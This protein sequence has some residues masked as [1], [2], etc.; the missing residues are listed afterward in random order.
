[1]MLGVTVQFSVSD[2]TF[3]IS[4]MGLLRSWFPFHVIAVFPSRLHVQL[5]LKCSALISYFSHAFMYNLNLWPWYA[6][7][8]YW[9]FALVYGNNKAVNFHQLI[10]LHT[11]LIQLIEILSPTCNPSRA[12][13]FCQILKYLTKL[14]WHQYTLDKALL[15]Y[16][17][18]LPV[19][20]AVI[21]KIQIQQRRFL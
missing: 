10:N 21:G 17:L 15:I 1:M 20:L 16:I 14:W 7:F 6:G 12:C 5:L 18:D 2:L 3:K 13:H 4:C 11:G 19:T 9:G 8:H